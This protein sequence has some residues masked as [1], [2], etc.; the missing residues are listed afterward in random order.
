MA[1]VGI[2]LSMT[3]NVSAM[4]PKVSTAL[5]DI[6]SAGEEMKE[7]LQLDDLE[8]KYRK[9]AERIDKIYDAQQERKFQR[10]EGARQIREEERQEQQ[11]QQRMSTLPTQVM[12]GVGAAATRAE[13]GDVA[14]AGGGLLAMLTGLLKSAGPVGWAALGLGGVAMA[15]MAVEQTYEKQ[16]PGI[17]A[18]SAALGRL[19]EETGAAGDIFR[20]TMDEVA[21]AGAEFAYSLEESIPIFRE[22][23]RAGGR[24]EKDVDVAME[25]ARGFGVDPTGLS[26]ALGIYQ[27]F[28]GQGNVLGMVAGGLE[29]SG[30]GKGRYQEFLDATL[31]VFEEGLSRGVVKGFEDIITTQTWLAQAGEIFTGQTGLNIYR[32]MEAA[33]VGA[34]GLAREQDIIL[35]RAAK[36]ALG[37]GASYLDI[38]KRLEGGI[39]PE[40]FKYVRQQIMGTPTTAGMAATKVGQIELLR[41]VFQDISYVTAETLRTISAE[42]GAAVVGKAPGI[43]SDETRVLTAQLKISQEIR[44]IGAEIVRTKAWVVEGA[45]RI[46]SGISWLL[47]VGEPTREEVML[48]L[49][50]EEKKWDEGGLRTGRM[51]GV[52]QTRTDF[53]KLMSW[54]LEGG[55]DTEAAK[56]LKVLYEN[57]TSE[58]REALDWRVG[59]G[60][61]EEGYFGSIIDWIEAIGFRHMTPGEIEAGGRPGLVPG[62][63]PVIL[64][65]LST[66]L[67][68]LST[69]IDADKTMNINVEDKGMSP[70]DYERFAKTGGID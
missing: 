65:R 26:G 11:T 14:G 44:N 23:A 58:Q 37:E 19:S 59:R 66:E 69:A 24:R 30:M 9:Y 49:E 1:D 5:R 38:Q 34:T 15:G 21:M 4:S 60:R 29:Q 63:L 62:D 33:T 17:M 7:A 64:E 32:K 70:A 61:M 45:E 52:A 42:G 57:M 16:L 12:G 22:F 25:Y 56:K 31:A 51:P 48:F 53:E 3:E 6:S 50:S 55:A 39:D 41:S 43:Q 67:N 10:Q 36:M 47:G 28:G 20:E 35:F 18:L 54:G 46:V 68:K 27:R 40:I 8:E 2:R 13:G